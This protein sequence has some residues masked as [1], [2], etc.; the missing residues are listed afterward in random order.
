MEEKL[1]LRVGKGRT[2]QDGDE[3]NKSYFEIEMVVDEKDL[4]A[5]TSWA[6]TLIDSWLPKSSPL[7]TSTAFTHRPNEAKSK[8]MKAFPEEYRKH[9][10]I[11][12][13]TGPDEGYTVIR[14]PFLSADIFGQMAHIVR[15]DLGGE[16]ISAGKDSRFR[17]RK[18]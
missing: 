8:I 16:H 4:E 17:I 1:N 5:K 6:T 13:G 15:E 18:N 12:E 2:V 7:K 3:W 10:T 9:L 11:E 14:I